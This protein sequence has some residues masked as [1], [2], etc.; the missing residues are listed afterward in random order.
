M[1]EIFEVAICIDVEI[2]K[3]Y[4]CV[5]VNEVYL[6]PL[7]VYFSGRPF[8]IFPNHEYLLLYACIFSNQ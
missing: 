3:M 8:N 2:L 5:S 6:K 4:H 7:L 1:A